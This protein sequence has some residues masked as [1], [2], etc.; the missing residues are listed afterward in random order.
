MH[1]TV[2]FLANPL[3]RFH[4]PNAPMMR[5]AES[6]KVLRAHMASWVDWIFGGTR[7]EQTIP[8]SSRGRGSAGILKEGRIPLTTHLDFQVRILGNW[9]DHF[10]GPVSRPGSGTA[11][12]CWRTSAFCGTGTT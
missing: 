3:R 8:G 10:A 2:C 11:R 6:G 12:V 5:V 1:L 7:L 4:A 9:A